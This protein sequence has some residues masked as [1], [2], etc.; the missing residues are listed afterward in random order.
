MFKLII[1]V[2]ALL[3]AYISLLSINQKYLAQYTWDF[4][5]NK[6]YTLS[7]ASQNLL[8]RVT[9]EIHFDFYYSESLARAHPKFAAYANNVRYFLQHYAAYSE[10]IHFNLID[11]QAFSRQAAQAQA[12]G[13]SA[14][15]TGAL[16]K[17]L[18]LGLVMQSPQKKQQ[19]VPFFYPDQAHLLEYQIS[20][21]LEQLIHPQKARLGVLT[22]L[23]LQGSFDF[24]K[25]RTRP[26]WPLWQALNQQYQVTYLGNSTAWQAQDFDLLLVLAPQHLNAKTLAQIKAAMLAQVPALIFVDPLPE[27]HTYPSISSV[28]DW[29]ASWGIQWSQETWTA[30]LNLGVQVQNDQGHIETNPSILRLTSDYF[31]K[32]HPSS[33]NLQHLVFASAGALE[34][35]QTHELQVQPLVWT[36]GQSVQQAKALWST[37]AATLFA[38]TP[39][40]D[41]S[42]ILAADIQSAQGERFALIADTDLWDLRFWGQET[43][44]LAKPYIQAWADNVSWILNLV[45]V[46][47]GA[48][49]LTALRTPLNI[50][51]PFTRVQA[52]Q[53]QADIEFRAQ[54]TVL[55]QTLA[56]LEQQLAPLLEANQRLDQDQVAQLEALLLQKQQMQQALVQVRQQLAQQVRALEYLL[57]GLNIVIFP[58][59]F[60]LLCAGFAW[61]IRQRKRTRLL[62]SLRIASQKQHQANC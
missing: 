7:H 48:P 54:E 11:V 33:Q 27:S 14:V 37:D 20:Q 2:I 43:Q 4:T 1:K 58:L 49:E 32:D 60:T 39:L 18:Y 44:V 13:L 24:E 40:G 28:T 59:G 38:Q 46:Y 53:R 8:D 36:S 21:H 9:E 31:A 42:F 5:E 57:K 61:H 26:A 17:D 41:A 23:P 16:A 52:L 62:V 55:A 19:V 12:L 10:K 6:M 3:V 29:L 51:R 50:E 34:F 15:P 47:L 45:D 22:L 30:D 56:E 35:S 25:A